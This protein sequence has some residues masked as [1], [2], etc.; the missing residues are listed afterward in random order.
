MPHRRGPGDEARQWQRETGEPHLGCHFDGK[1]PVFPAQDRE[2]VHTKCPEK[3]PVYVLGNLVLISTPLWGHSGPKGSRLGSLPQEG[4][5]WPECRGGLGRRP[6][7][8]AGLEVRGRPLYA[9]SWV[10]V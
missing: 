7:G 5:K 6:A 4:T 9:L 2:L 10:V 8:P 3:R 1:D